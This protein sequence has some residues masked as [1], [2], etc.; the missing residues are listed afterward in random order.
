MYY[1]KHNDN[2]IKIQHNTYNITYLY[3]TS[4]VF[5]L[6]HLLNH[7]KIAYTD[8]DNN[9]ILTT[10]GKKYIYYNSDKKQF[11]ILNFMPYMI[12][13]NKSDKR[14][15]NYHN[16]NKLFNNIINIDAIDTISNKD[17]YIKILH[18]SLKNNVITSSYIEN[19]ICQRK[20]IYPGKLG[21]LLSHIQLWNSILQDNLHDWALIMEDDIHIQPPNKININNYIINIINYV[22]KYYPHCKYI[23]LFTHP[24]FYEKQFST[25]F[26]L[27]DDIIF[28]ANKSQSGNVAYLIHKNGI[29]ILKN[30]LFPIS[31][32]FDHSI[33]NVFHMLNAI[34]IKNNIFDTHGSIT[35]DDKYSRLGSIIF[36]I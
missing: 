19:V 8:E 26:H 4:N 1:L 7:I 30:N 31:T 24:N 12:V 29:Q 27:M 3:D 34:S 9:I 23:K 18:R 35:I 36:N 2:I 16:T 33:S 21:V 15:A 13:Y 22:T 20:K 25:E 17:N 5:Y 14:V 32:Y 6:M 10:K 11:I 28:K